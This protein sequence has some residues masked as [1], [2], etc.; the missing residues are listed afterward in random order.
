MLIP[1]VK[2]HGIQVGVWCALSAARTTGPI[3]FD[4]INSNQY[5]VTHILTTIFVHL[6]DYER[7]YAF[8]HQH[9]TTA[10]TLLHCLEC[11]WWQNNKPGIVASSFTRSEPT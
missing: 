10:H 2:L 1:E 4:T 7:T 9:S 6:S 5:V 3:F 8:Q 11:F